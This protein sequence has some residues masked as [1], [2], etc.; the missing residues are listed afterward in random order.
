MNLLVRSWKFCCILLLAI[1]SLGDAHE[2]SRRRVIVDTDAALDDMR[3]LILLLESDVVDVVGVVTSDGACGPERGARNVRLVLSALGHG[4]I[5]VAA[6]PSIDQPPPPWRVMSESLGWTDLAPPGDKNAQSGARTEDFRETTASDLIA[7]ILTDTGA[8]VTYVCLGPLTNLAAAVEA[9]PSLAARLVSVYYSGSG[10]DAEPPSWNTARD[11]Q[12]AR[13]VFGQPLAPRAIRPGGENVLR[14]DV[15][16]MESVC[17]GASVGAA[18]M[19]KLHGHERVLEMVRSGHF[20]CWDETVVLV[21][22]FPEIC[23]EQPQA[24]GRHDGIFTR[25]DTAAAR[26]R[27]LSVLAGDLSLKAGRRNPVVLRRYP[28]EP[29]LLRDDVAD[30][31]AAI[32][33]RHGV[34]EWNAA[35]LASELHRHLGIYSILGVKMGIRAREILDAGVDELRVTSLAGSEPPLSC[36]TDGLQVA[37]GAT[38]GRGTVEVAPGESAPAAVFVM[39]GRRVRLELEPSVSARIGADIKST[40]DKY[41][42]LTPDYWRAVRDLSLRYWLEMNRREIFIE[43]VE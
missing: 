27:Y 7:Q 37:T 5:P 35:L 6:G 4:R 22:L 31:A 2:P 8:D 15:G 1:S 10:P 36:L 33:E 40:I 32:V 29:A 25:C 19:C 12:A 24:A 42:P 14:F 23:G 16:L 17:A 13:A 34:E 38:L 28:T 21:M 18:L 41:G 11:L 9:A 26:V 30:L 3:A 43:R 20:V 39:D